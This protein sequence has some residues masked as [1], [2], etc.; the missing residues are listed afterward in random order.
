MTS[1]WGSLASHQSKL[2]T[3]PT[4]SNIAGA[5]DTLHACRTIVDQTA[6]TTTQCA[7]NA[8]STWNALCMVS[9]DNGSPLQLKT[10]CACCLDG[11]AFCTCSCS[12]FNAPLPGWSAVVLLVPAGMEGST[13]A[14]CI[15]PDAVS[16]V[17]NEKNRKGK[18]TPFGVNL[19]R[20]QALYRAAQVYQ[21]HRISIESCGDMLRSLSSY[22]CQQQLS[23]RPDWQKDL[24]D[25]SHESMRC[26]AAQ[27]HS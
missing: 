25:C 27:R 2:H 12:S 10:A 21:S 15:K 3:F 16:K 18:T 11:S 5:K 13:G 24:R 22:L 20:S 26:N 17:E 14:S 6:C 23:L 19:M 7:C 9:G 4:A 8:C 1:L